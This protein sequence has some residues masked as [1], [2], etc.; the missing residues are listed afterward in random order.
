MFPNYCFTK[1]ARQ[2]GYDVIRRGYS[3]KDHIQRS[4]GR[5]SAAGEKTRNRSEIRFSAENKR[6]KHQRNFSKSRSS[7]DKDSSSRSVAFRLTPVDCQS[8]KTI[9]ETAGD[10]R[11]KDKMSYNASNDPNRDLQESFADFFSIIHDNVL[12]SVQEAVQR[13][14]SKCFEESLTKME[15]LSNELEQQ[16]TLLNKIHRDVTS[17][18]SAQSETNLNQFKFV[19]QMLIDNQTVHYR[20]LNQAKVNK[21]RRKEERDLEKDRK[22]ERERK[23]KC[24]CQEVQNAERVRRCRSSSPDLSKRSTGDDASEFMPKSPQHQL[25]QQ[26]APLVYQMCTSCTNQEPMTRSQRTSRSSS[27]HTNTPVLQRRSTSYSMPDLSGR[28]SSISGRFSQP[29][30]SSR[31]CLCRSLSNRQDQIVCL[32]AMTYPPYVRNVPIPRR[33]LVHRKKCGI[34]QSDGK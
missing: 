28:T 1:S 26:Q 6:P 9:R 34:G 25:C 2:S 20:A 4:S 14:V 13:M 24:G 33:R 19:T 5:N 18:I 10:D 3:T 32:P 29:Q 27:K 30:P 8:K 16:K 21:Q 31:T 11:Q 15:R 12:E 22:Q 23:R 17:K 7:R